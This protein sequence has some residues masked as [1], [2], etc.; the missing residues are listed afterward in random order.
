MRYDRPAL[1][2][3][4]QAARHV[5]LALDENQIVRY[6]GLEMSVERQAVRYDRLVVPGANR[7]V[8]YDRLVVPGE[9]RIV[10]YDWRVVSVVGAWCC[11]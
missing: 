8:R 7:I 5:W 11:S 1:S 3:E 10:R 2:V 4:K 9:N 6:D